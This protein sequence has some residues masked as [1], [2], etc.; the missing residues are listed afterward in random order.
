MIS[1]TARD[2]PEHRQMV[3][4]A[5]QRL[6]FKPTSHLSSGLVASFGKLRVPVG[7]HFEVLGKFTIELVKLQLSILGA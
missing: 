2:L 3:M 5:C 7:G 4:D 6:G 1:S